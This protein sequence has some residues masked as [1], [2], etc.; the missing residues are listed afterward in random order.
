MR[1]DSKLPACRVEILDKAPNILYLFW[2]LLF[3]LCSILSLS[4]SFH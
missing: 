1:A 4:C 2:L 3:N